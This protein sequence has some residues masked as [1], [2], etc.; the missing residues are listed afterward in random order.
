GMVFNVKERKEMYTKISEI[1]S[2]IRQKYN[3]TIDE[4]MMLDA[5]SRGY[6]SGLGDKYSR[7]LSKSEYEKQLLETQGKLVG[8][9]VTI[10]RDASG[11]AQVV[12]VIEGSP[13]ELA[14][15]LSGDMITAIDE[16][17]LKTYDFTKVDELIRGNAGTKVKLNI[18][19]EGVETLYELARKDIDIKYVTYKLIDKN[20]YIKINEFNQKTY[21]QFKN[22]VDDLIK[23]GATGLVFDLRDN[24]GGTLDSAT[25]MLDMLLPQG[26]IATKTDKSGAT[27]PLA[28][29]D[30]YGVN[31]PMVT[32]IN[33]NTASASE[34]FVSALRDFNK[35][36]SIGTTT[37]GKG[38]M[39]T[40]IPL[41][42]GSAL[43]I[44]TA[45]FI[46]PS[47]EDFNGVGI[48]PDNE[49]KF[50]PEQ[51]QN[52]KNGHLELESDTQFVKAV[53]VLNSKK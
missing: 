44:T 14:G 22:A 51:E 33:G 25:K 45:S 34:L 43:S 11:Y 32:I 30:K 50:T 27:S 49:V 12:K 42:D 16:V 48:K 10:K 3:G 38:V 47:G 1:D 36:T 41:K 5:I 28:T 37:Y 53:E 15:I 2:E 21:E 23:Q 6:V 52:F 9:G 46:P 39:Q 18:R 35:A 4:D 29:S 8:I 20:G 31:L 26:V 24:G 40:L 13:A 17:D 19:R 7:Y